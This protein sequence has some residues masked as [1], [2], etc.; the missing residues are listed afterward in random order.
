MT[1]IYGRELF[2]DKLRNDLE[3]TQAYLLRWIQSTGK[4]VSY[5]TITAFGRNPYSVKTK[6]YQIIMGAIEEIEKAKA[7]SLEWDK[8]T[9]ETLIE[10]NYRR[11]QYGR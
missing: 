10:E 6:N 11:Y 8:E 9:K 2:R 4:S 7:Y 3:I 5:D 1:E